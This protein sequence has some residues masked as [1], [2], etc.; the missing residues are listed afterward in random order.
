MP[1]Y[2]FEKLG[3]STWTLKWKTT[4][5]EVTIKIGAFVTCSLQ[6]HNLWWLVS[7]HL[8]APA[9][10]QEFQSQNFGEGTG[11]LGSGTTLRVA[12][13]FSGFLGERFE[14]FSNHEC[15]KY[16][17]FKAYIYIFFWFY[18]K[19]AYIFSHFWIHTPVGP[20]LSA[21]CKAFGWTSMYT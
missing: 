14:S 12:S 13:S 10:A 2:L 5:H 4:S 6:I 21:I 8:Q 15:F 17:K 20:H 18:I 7:A 19:I 3:S 9:R 16:I 11:L 1:W